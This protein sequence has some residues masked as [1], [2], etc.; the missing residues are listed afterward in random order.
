MRPTH[1]PSDDI[2]TSS[3]ADIAF[4]LVIFFMITLTF[5][6]TRGL[7]FAPAGDD[8]PTITIDPVEAVLVE[9]ER[10]GLLFVDRRPI[11]AEQVVDYLA[12]RLQANPMKPV[13]LRASQSATYGDFAGAFDLLRRIGRELNLENG[14]Q[15]TI[16]TEREIQAYWPAEG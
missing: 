1:R 14:I 12:L 11:R 4:L 3:M 16:P 10:G 13:L 8:E 9:V 6:A 5:S 7:D 15:L 2:P